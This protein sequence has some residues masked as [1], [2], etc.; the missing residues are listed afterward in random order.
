MIFIV[1]YVLIFK[2]YFTY[3]YGL[4]ATFPDKYIKRIFQIS[5]NAKAQ[6][7]LNYDRRLFPYNYKNILHVMKR[8]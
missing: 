8:K 2:I 1:L 4:C 7:F 6:I 3:K 5:I